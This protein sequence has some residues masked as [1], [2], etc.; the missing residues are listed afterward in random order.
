MTR[1]ARYQMFLNRKTGIKIVIT[2]FIKV[3][4]QEYF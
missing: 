3:L 4:S 1:R 2:E